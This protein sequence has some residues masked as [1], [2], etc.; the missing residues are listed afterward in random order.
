MSKSWIEA[1]KETYYRWYIGAAHYPFASLKYQSRTYLTF[2]IWWGP[3]ISIFL[4]VTS[5]YCIVYSLNMYC[6]IAYKRRTLCVGRTKR[7][8]KNWSESLK[9]FPWSPPV[10]P[11]GVRVSFI[12]FIKWFLIHASFFRVIFIFLLFFLK[13][14]YYSLHLLIYFF[15]FFCI[16][17]LT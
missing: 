2:Y 9:V 3:N 10:C 13:L 12:I 4:F 7:I 1:A 8:I 5:I 15:L 14:L 11:C 16:F 6:K 17:S